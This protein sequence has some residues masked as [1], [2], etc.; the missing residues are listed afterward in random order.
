MHR[1]AE[2]KRSGIRLRTIRPDER[3][4]IAFIHPGDVA[5]AFMD[6]VLRTIMPE[7]HQGGL[8]GDGG[9]YINLQ[10]GPRIAEARS[11][12]LESYLNAAMYKDGEWILCV[13]AD[14]VF[15]R[16]DV[17]TL[18]SAA[19]PIDRPIVGGLCFAGYSPET[20]YPTLY[21]LTEED[22]SWAMDK[23]TDYPKD[24]MVKV[25]A[26]GAAFLLCHRTALYKIYNA[27]KNLP[28][29]KLNSY[30]WFVEGHVDHK[31]RQLGEDVAFCMRAN[32]V[33]LP[34]Y[35]HT[36]VRIGHRKNWVLTEQ[37]YE[38]MQLLARVRSGE[39]A[40]EI[41]DQLEMAFT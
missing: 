10:S 4:V 12:V 40:E 34:V 9:G 5:G 32:A 22:G 17:R 21:S 36:G 37:V 19:D 24:A 25:G 3:C 13:D 16:E 11:Q 7:A 2:A 6:S 1:A 30:P 27:F 18:I 8:M 33:G 41:K 14:M 15:T 23:V 31:G 28:D 20:M 35:V 38:D 26:T 39:Y 29:G